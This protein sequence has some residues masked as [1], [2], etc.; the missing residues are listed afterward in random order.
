MWDLMRDVAVKAGQIPAPPRPSFARDIQP[1][2]E[3]LSRLQWVNAG[4]AAAF[5][6]GAPSDLAAPERLAQLASPAPAAQE[7]RRVIA[8][9]F[10]V[11]DRDAWSPVPWPW[12]YGDAMAVPTPQT[13]RAFSTLSDLQ[14]RFLAQWAAGDFE[15]DYDPQA[16]PP[17]R[18]EDVP[19]AE[20]GAM[21]DRAALEFCLADAFHP[22][23]E[24]TWPMRQAAMYEGPFRVAH[25]KEAGSNP[26]SARPSPRHDR[27][28]GRA[29]RAAGPGRP[30]RWMAVPGRPTRRAAARATLP[31]TIPTSLP[32][33][34][35]GCPTRCSPRRT[36]GS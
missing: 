10:R 17:A 31:P 32:S 18:L 9:Q 8:N 13:P 21:L 22:G 36:T 27:S 4:F 2:L 20:Q 26:I 15:A 7:M 29:H 19:V 33:G 16:K 30:H 3:R 25:V 6:F 23:C 14:M 35:R 5:G 24:M 11:V 12:L 34:R 28:A 1:I